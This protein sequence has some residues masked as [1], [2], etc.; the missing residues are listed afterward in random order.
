MKSL[1][2]PSKNPPK[3]KAPVIAGA[4]KQGEEMKARQGRGLAATNLSS[5]RRMREQYASG[6][7]TLG[8]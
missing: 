5:M 8:Q 6:K 4:E 1:F 3:P 7:T 2:V